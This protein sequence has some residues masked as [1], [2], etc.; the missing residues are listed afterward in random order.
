[1]LFQTAQSDATNDLG[2]DERTEVR[3]Q[4][5]RDMTASDQY[6]RFHVLFERVASQVRACQKCGAAVGNCHF[7]VDAT[8]SEWRWPVRPGI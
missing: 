5:G 1:M 7:C 3:L 6:S 8:I 2:I 4:T